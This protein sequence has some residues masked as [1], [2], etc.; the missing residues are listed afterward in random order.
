MHHE[1][2][3]YAFGCLPANNDGFK[4]ENDDQTENNG[5]KDVFDG[6]EEDDAKFVSVSV[7]F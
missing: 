2:F 1:M 5:E 3:E 7:R 4:K 6:K